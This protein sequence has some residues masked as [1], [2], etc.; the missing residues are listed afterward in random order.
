MNLQEY[1]AKHLFEGCGIP[2]PRAALVLR[3]LDVPLAFKGL[4]GPFFVVKAQVRAGGRGKGVFKDGYEGGVRV[5][6]GETE[7]ASAARAMLGNTL[8]THQTGPSGERVEAVYI[9]EGVDIQREYYLALLLDTSKPTVM[10][11]VSSQGGVDIEEVART[12]PEKIEYLPLDFNLGITAEQIARVAEILGLEKVTQQLTELLK[13]LWELFWQKDCLLVEINPLV[14]TKCGDLLALDAKV[15]LDENALF[16]HVELQAYLKFEGENSK[17]AR[18]KRARLSYIA[19]DGDIACL[20]NGAGLA[21][22]TM[23]LIHHYGGR[24]ANFLD[25]GGSATVE[26]VTEAFRIL[27]EDGRVRAVWV[28]IFGGIM[29]CRTIA[30]GIVAAVVDIRPSVPLVVRLEGN[31]VEAARTLLADSSLPLV[32]V[33]G[34]RDGAKAVLKQAGLP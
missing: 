15:Q 5:C 8:V 16:R 14:L 33:E 21:M 6:R 3:E 2:V 13:S 11:M 34:L 19:L 7:A 20:V 27:L 30:E 26:A 25:V 22:A 28:N 9:T 1:Q 23:D 31:E 29:S 24:P 17:E 12:H 10:L 32:V 4:K 18:A